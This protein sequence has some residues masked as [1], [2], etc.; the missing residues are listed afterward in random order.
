[1]TRARFTD[2][3][4]QALYDC[5]APAESG[6]P[7]DTAEA[8]AAREGLDLAD[9]LAAARR[10]TARATAARRRTDGG[11]HRR[12]DRRSLERHAFT[13]LSREA[14]H[15]RPSALRDRAR[16]WATVGLWPAEM[17][18]W[19]R[20]V[21]VDGAAIARDCRTAGITL[22]AMNVLLDGMRVKHRLRGGEP[23]FAVLARATSSGHCLS[24]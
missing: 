23:A 2:T 19:I 16:A 1:M 22:S 5:L 14:T 21:G 15:L 13:L 10:R 24:E 20:A 7:A 8:I 11:K 12:D 3:E 17:E 18:A 4:L 6:T 9:D